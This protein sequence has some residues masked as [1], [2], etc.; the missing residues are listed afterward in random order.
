MICVNGYFHRK[1]REPKSPL[2][3]WVVWAVLPSLLLVLCLG[4][5]EDVPERPVVSNKL[6]RF[7]L[8]IF[9]AIMDDDG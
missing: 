1:R 5:R 7:E 6:P 9:S 4:C 3:S 2:L 8:A